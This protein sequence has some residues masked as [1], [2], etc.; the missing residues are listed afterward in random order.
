MEVL[1]F[2]LTRKTNRFLAYLSESGQTP[3]SFSTDCVSR[4]NNQLPERRSVGKVSLLF[5]ENKF[6]AIG[7]NSN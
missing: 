4:T 2:L 7:P 6:F 3:G 5:I 1:K